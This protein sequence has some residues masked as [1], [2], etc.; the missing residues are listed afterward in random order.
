MQ[1]KGAERRYDL[2]HE[3]MPFHDGKFESWR[4]KPD[5]DH[6]F[7][8]RDGVTIWMAETDVNPEDKFLG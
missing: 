5:P 2:R 6:L 1:Q 8:Y 3:D 4:E 7:H